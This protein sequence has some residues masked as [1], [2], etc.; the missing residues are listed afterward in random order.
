MSST[1]GLGIMFA[2]REEGGLDNKSKLL[3]RLQDMI[4]ESYEAR[5][6]VWERWKKNERLYIGNPPKQADTRSDVK[7]AI[8]LAVIEDELPQIRDNMPV[9]DIVGES[10]NDA[11]FADMI[12]RRVK[13]LL[14]NADYEEAQEN[15]IKNGHIYNVGVYEALPVLIEGKKGETLGGLD[16]NVYDTMGLF[17]DPIGC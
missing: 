4:T 6:D 5:K 9:I 3:I 10:Q 7:H 11:F 12:N 13:Q 8:A 15:T 16:I 2:N 14:A 17:M 1:T